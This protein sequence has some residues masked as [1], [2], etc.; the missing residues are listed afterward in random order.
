MTVWFV[1]LRSTKGRRRYRVNLDVHPCPTILAQGIGCNPHSRSVFLHQYTLDDDGR[2]RMTRSTGK[3]PYRVPAM[4]EVSAV[5]SCGRTIVSLFSGCGGSCLRFR[6][7]GFRVAYASE[8]V[9]AA[10]AVYEANSPGTFVDPR[11]VRLVTPEEILERIGMAA[12]ELDVLEGSPPC[13]A[14]STAGK[15]QDTWGKTRKYSDVEQRSDDLFFEYARILRGLQPKAFVA[16]NVSGLVK[17]A[18]LG[19]FKQILAELQSCGYAVEARLLD[20]QWLGVPQM[21]QRIIFVGV[22]SDLGRAPAHPE[23][24]PYRYSVRDALPDLDLEYERHGPNSFQVPADAN[25]IPAL[26]IATQPNG[27]S[28]YRHKAHV[29]GRAAAKDEPIGTILASNGGFSDVSI[30]GTQRRK[31]TIPEVKAL[32]SFPADFDLTPAGTY[33]KQWER[34]GR[35]VPPLMMRAVA[36]V[37]RDV[38]LAGVP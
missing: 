18:A 27:S 12:G 34:L 15:R 37:L 5:P 3:P 30:D 7:A 35:A 6:M 24:L 11:D 19:Y 13:A 22:R 25:S 10:R 16:E 17:G 29:R 36:E 21:R 33:N 28:W 4:A 32:C 20:A 8:F 14:F 26:T 38:V 1:P 2:P 31:L 9:E 23:P